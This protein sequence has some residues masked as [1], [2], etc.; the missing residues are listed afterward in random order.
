M[1]GMKVQLSSSVGKVECKA[2]TIN[3]AIYDLR[4]ERHLGW[5]DGFC[6]MFKIACCGNV[7]L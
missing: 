2:M 3:V 7:E 6:G 5:S 4:Q 1:T